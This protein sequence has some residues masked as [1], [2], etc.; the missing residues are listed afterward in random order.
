MQLRLSNRM[1]KPILSTSFLLAVCAILAVPSRALA[2]DVTT[3]TVPVEITD[4]SLQIGRH[5]LDLPPGQWF[6]AQI[7]HRDIGHGREKTDAYDA[8]AVAVDGPKVRMV[9]KVSLPAN[10]TPR[11]RRWVFSPCAAPEGIL[12]DDLSGGLGQPECLAIFGHEHLRHVFQRRAAPVAQWIAAHGALDPSSGAVEFTYLKR[13][14]KSFGA[15]RIFMPTD[16][17]AADDD[18]RKWAA[19]LRDAMEPLFDDEAS[20]VRLPAIPASQHGL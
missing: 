18:A 15:L 16:S 8:W 10:N 6:L 20:E 14:E 5:K 2:L 9:V 1:S 19:S 13:T 3:A 12:R 17:F 4:G 7:D 11:A